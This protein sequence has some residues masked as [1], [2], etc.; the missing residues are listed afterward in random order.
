LWPREH[1]THI[2]T[3][4]IAL[5]AESRHQKLDE[6][7]FRSHHLIHVNENT[8]IRETQCSKRQ[9]YASITQTSVT[10]E[11]L[12]LQFCLK[13][14]LIEYKYSYFISATN[15]RH[16]QHGNSGNKQHIKSILDTKRCFSHGDKNNWTHMTT[17]QES[18]ESE[19]S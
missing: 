7:V 2:H 8:Y 15:D 4:Y 9:V 18:S 13:F 3:K 5:E 17:L 10:F 11:I 16:L 6:N 19:K 14:S 12:E 1:S